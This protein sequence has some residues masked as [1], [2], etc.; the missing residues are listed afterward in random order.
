MGLIEGAIDGQLDNDR[1]GVIVGLM[2]GAIDRLLVGT[3]D[4]TISFAVG[5]LDGC[6]DG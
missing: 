2:E 1:V 5:S 4:D 3:E 6:A